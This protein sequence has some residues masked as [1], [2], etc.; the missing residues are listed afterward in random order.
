MKG[1]YIEKGETPKD[2]HKMEE[3]LG[4]ERDVYYSNDD[5]ERY[6]ITSQSTF[7]QNMV[8]NKININEDWNMIKTTKYST[9]F[10]KE[11]PS[12]AENPQRNFGPLIHFPS[13]QDN[14]VKWPEW[15]NQNKF[16]NFMKEK[17]AF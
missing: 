8:G 9:S 16:T 13:F 17:E 6:Q 14:I 4:E 3:K 7:S 12:L 15:K 5:E 10:I 1:Y 11:N 2:F